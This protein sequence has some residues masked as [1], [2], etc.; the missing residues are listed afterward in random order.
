MCPRKTIRY[1]QLGGCALQAYKHK[2]THKH[3]V[4]AFGAAGTRT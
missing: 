4:S 3:R 1:S 2:Y